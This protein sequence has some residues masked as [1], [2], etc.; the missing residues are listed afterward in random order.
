MYTLIQLK[1]ALKNGQEVLKA[2]EYLGKDGLPYCRKCNTPRFHTDSVNVIRSECECQ[3]AVT[4][5][6]LEQEKRQKHIEEFY[7]RQKLSLI[8]ERYKDKMFKDATITFSNSEIYSRCRNYVENA[9]ILYDNN[10]GLYIY[11]DNSSGKTFLTS[12]MCN[13]LMW[14]GWRCLYTNLAYILDAIYSSNEIISRLELYPFVFIDDIGKEFIGREYNAGMAK[15]AE[16]KLFEIL[17]A[18]YNAKKPTIFSSNYSIMEL[19]EVLRLDKGIVDR[20]NEMSTRVLKLS[21]DDFRKDI[22]KKNSEIAKKFNI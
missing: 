3:R 15:W 4:Q 21:G 1:L 11:G 18:R 16:Q 13:E 22:Q 6:R 19:Y 7:N 14:R 5:K 20:I 9:R 8:G 12:C 2:D 17:N 10:I